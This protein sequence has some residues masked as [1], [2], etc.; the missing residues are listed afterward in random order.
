[1]SQL[2]MFNF[3]NNSVRV[4][5]KDVEPW[6]V[7]KDVCD[8]LGIKNVSDAVI[9]LND[10]FKT[11]IALTET[12]SNYKTN[13][14]VVNEPGL[15]KLI[16]KSRKAE[17]EKFSDWLAEEV[18]PSIRKHGAYLTPD[19]LQQAIAEPSFAIGLLQALDKERQE[20][21]Q[22]QTQIQAD[23]PYTNFGKVVSLSNGAINI[24]HFA[25]ILYDEHGINIGRNKLIAWLRDNNYL[26]KQEGAEKNLPKQ[27]YI[28]QGL[29]KVRPAIIK[30]TVGDV[31][32]GTTL[33][34]GKGQ[35]KLAEILL[36]EFSQKVI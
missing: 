27:R 13:A 7:A 19:A 12:G 18:I 22:L 14:L 21:Q 34:T 35:V 36:Q 30:R 29:F 33:V 32:G 10:N 6:F 24:G 31:Q 26:I 25:K 8:I 15:Y 17:A 23:E 11:T 4:I 1:M 5:Q 2:Q 9:K 3:E 20:K 16:F 28:E